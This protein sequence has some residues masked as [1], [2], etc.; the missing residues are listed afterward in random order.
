MRRRQFFE[1]LGRAGAAG[2]ASA[3]LGGAAVQQ[4]AAKFRAWTWFHGDNA[5]GRS[6]WQRR[7]ARLRAAGITG[8]L[9]EGGDS[10]R[11]ASA[12]GSEGL[13]LHRWIFT[14]YRSGDRWA[15]RNHP[16]WFSVSRNGQSSLTRPPYV[17]SYNWLCPNREG[18][19]EYLRSSVDRIAARSDVAGVHLDYIRF[20]DVILPRGLWSRYGLVQDREM[21][22]FDFCYCD[23]CREKF[24]RL[25]GLDPMKLADAPEHGAWREFRWRSI[26]EL[27]ALLS[28]TVRERGKAISAAV[29]AT[30]AL[31][32]RLVR[33]AWDEW[34]LDA[35]F[36]MLYHNFYLEDVAWIGRA[37]REGV[38]AL[39]AGVPLYAGLFVPR[40]DPA[41]LARAVALAR[42]AGAAGVALFSMPRL[43]GAHLATLGRALRS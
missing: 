9:V 3:A 27:V 20:I 29:F 36:P 11:I 10:G 12:A 13:E 30:P 31:A 4:P 41:A 21:A 26:S 38:N 39:P 24:R 33:Q 34:P 14:L 32:R 8:L 22:Q 5:T 25:S 19:R 6:E 18:V 7:F 35:V 28:R 37:A 43:S 42:D 2:V 23:V 17:P 15:K 16:E 1:L 40:L